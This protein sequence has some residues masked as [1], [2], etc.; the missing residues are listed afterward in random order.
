[1]LHYVLHVVGGH[2]F[3]LR[4]QAFDYKRAAFTLGLGL[5]LGLGNETL[6]GLRFRLT[7]MWRSLGLESGLEIGLEIGLEMGLG[8]GT[9]MMF[10]PGRTQELPRVWY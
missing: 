6:K 10:W 5:G 2:G 8:L 7:D 3:Q 9:F 4:D 1:M